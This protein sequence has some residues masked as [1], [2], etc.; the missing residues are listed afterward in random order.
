MVAKNVARL[1]S[2]LLV[3]ASAQCALAEDI[4]IYST[5][6]TVTPDAPNVLIYVDNTANWSQSFGGSTKFAAEKT[7]LATVV[8]ALKTQFR[9]GIMMASETGG[10]NSNTDGGYVRFAIQDMT[11]SDGTASDARNCL[12]KMVGSG[13]TC[14]LANS[15]YYT[16]LDINSDK[17]NGG[18]AGVTMAETYDYFAGL[19]AYAGNNKIKTDY[20]RVFTSGAIAGPTYKSPIST[21]C[22]KNFIIVISNGPFQDNS[23][24]SST[25]MSQ[26]GTA[27]GD[28]TVIN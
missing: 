28:T 22:Q 16:N 20:T 23:S 25:A 6:T 2:S 13:S 14:V 3:A 8:G 15:T 18:K 7:A 5:N 26:L 12:L 24:D 11:K 21:A 9:L 1:V 10:G 17:S 27:G 19:N 4:D